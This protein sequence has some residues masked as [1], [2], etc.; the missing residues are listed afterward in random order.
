[1]LYYELCEFFCTNDVPII[2]PPARPRLRAQAT[3]AATGG[4]QQEQEVSTAVAWSSRGFCFGIMNQ[5]RVLVQTNKN[6]SA[7]QTRTHRRIRKIGEDA[8][9]DAEWGTRVCE[10]SLPTPPPVSL[11]LSLFVLDW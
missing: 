7:A 2:L 6:R 3:G 5:D 1:M 10:F 9:P 4:K 8:T 11:S